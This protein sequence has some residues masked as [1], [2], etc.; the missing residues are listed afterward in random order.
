MAEM[1]VKTN[2]VLDE[3][4]DT[5]DGSGSSLGDGGGDTTHCCPLLAD[6]YLFP[7]SYRRRC[8]DAIDAVCRGMALRHHAMRYNVLRKST[9]KPGMPMNSFLLW[10]QWLSARWSQ[11]MPAP[12]G[13]R[14]AARDLLDILGRGSNSGRHLV[15][16]FGGV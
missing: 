4:L 11:A 15:G 5:L 3:E 2:L 9:T 1:A 12:G 8:A 14:T 10:L 13:W 6:V 16:G 7:I